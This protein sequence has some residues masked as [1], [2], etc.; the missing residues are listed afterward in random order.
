MTLIVILN[1][2]LAAVVLL[3]IPG[4]LGWAIRSSRSLPEPATGRARRR[5]MR[6]SY[7]A[8]QA[9]PVS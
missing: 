1:V 9:A 7:A 3:A 2:V 8:G 6:P 4:M 5:A